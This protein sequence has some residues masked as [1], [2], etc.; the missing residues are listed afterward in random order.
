[1]NNPNIEPQTSNHDGTICALATPTGGA[2]GIIRVSGAESL[3]I[4]SRIFTKD[5]TQAKGYTLHYGSIKAEDGTTIDE[6]LVTVFRAP[7]PT[8]ARIAW[9]Y[10]V[11]VRAIL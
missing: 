5:L 2:L 6:V 3:N 10:P 4:I 1:M 7:T 8:Q 9:K 11:T